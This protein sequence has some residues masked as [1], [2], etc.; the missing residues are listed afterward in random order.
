MVAEGLKYGFA[1][2]VLCVAAMPLVC[3]VLLLLQALRGGEL[4]RDLGGALYLG[5]LLWIPM[6]SGLSA[7][8]PGWRPWIGAP[9][10]FCLIVGPLWQRRSTPPATVSTAASNA[11]VF[12]VLALFGWTTMGGGYFDKLVQIPYSDHR[13]R[14]REIPEDNAAR[15][16][17][18]LSDDEVWVRWAAARALQRL[19]VSAAP[20]LEKLARATGDADG[21][22][23]RQ[24]FDA[25]ERIGPLAG[26]AAPVMAARIKEGRLDWAALRYFERLGA[27]ANAAVPAL[28]ALL[29]DPTPE[30]RAHALAALGCVGPAAKEQSLPVLA[31]LSRTEADVS[32]KNSLHDAQSKLGITLA[33]W[34]QAR[35]S[36]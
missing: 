8:H 21:R 24:A 30:V 14:E 2:G 9:A 18:A 19:G 17:L 15:L 33:E 12:A 1:T 13:L 35:A 11:A 10:A 4:S 22:V 23:A 34:E 20:A 3:L 5:G 25:I 26:P 7:I 32:V 29:E 31:R 6:L 16:G 28:L 27:E 36:P